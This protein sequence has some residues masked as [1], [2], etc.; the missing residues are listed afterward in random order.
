M[1]GQGEEMCLWSPVIVSRIPMWCLPPA[2]SWNREGGQPGAQDALHPCSFP[3]RGSPPCSQQWPWGNL[4]GDALTS[5]Y[6]AKAAFVQS[7]C[8]LAGR[9]IVYH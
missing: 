3:S 2:G 9:Q 6:G 8:C 1:E 4:E 7:N 5:G